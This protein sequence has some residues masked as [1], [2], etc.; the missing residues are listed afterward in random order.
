LAYFEGYRLSVNH[1]T[2]YE[3]AVCFIIVFTKQ[4]VLI[5]W[6]AAIHLKSSAIAGNLSIFAS[7]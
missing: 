4:A 1:Q 5:S 6:L 3:T 7:V 2:L